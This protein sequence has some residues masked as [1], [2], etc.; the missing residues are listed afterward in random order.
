[1]ADQSQLYDALESRA[2][3]I[4]GKNNRTIQYAYDDNG[5]LIE[6]KTIVTPVDEADPEVIVELVTYG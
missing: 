5:S 4:W 1:M 3:A 2:E 6:Q